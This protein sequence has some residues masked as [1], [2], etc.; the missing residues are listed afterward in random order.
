MAKSLRFHS[1]LSG[2]LASSLL[3]A[4]L[5]G[6]PGGD[7]DGAVS[8]ADMAAHVERICGEGFGSVM[9]ASLRYDCET[10]SYS[11]SA[12]RC[13][14]S[15]DRCDDDSLG[16]CDIHDRHWSCDPGTGTADCPPGLKCNDAEEDDD[17]PNAPPARP[18]AHLDPA[19][20]V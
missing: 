4:G 8:C 9:A 10:F 11:A 12:K 19:G 15:A 3:V 20:S 1:R 6:C 13:V 16:A 17:A 18:L 5:F 7:D 2:Q 14:L